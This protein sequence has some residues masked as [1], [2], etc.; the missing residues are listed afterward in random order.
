[1]LNYVNS[2]VSYAF[3]CAGLGVF[4]VAAGLW[5]FRNFMSIV[6][7]IWAVITIIAGL[8]AVSIFLGFFAFIGIGVWVLVMAIALA[9]RPGAAPVK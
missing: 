9:I 7:R 1:M 3:T 5:L 4:F 6:S 8:A 2:D